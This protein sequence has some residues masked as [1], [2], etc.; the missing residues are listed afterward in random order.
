MVQ[1]LLSSIGIGFALVFGSAFLFSWIGEAS[2]RRSISA[3]KR[4]I[5][6]VEPDALIAHFNKEK[7]NVGVSTFEVMRP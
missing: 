2:K 1:E 3:K 6:R 5:T 7:K 4:F